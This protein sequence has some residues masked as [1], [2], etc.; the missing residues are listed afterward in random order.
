MIPRQKNGA[1]RR[2]HGESGLAG[3]IA[4]QQ[5]RIRRGNAGRAKA[6]SIND[7][8]DSRIHG[9]SVVFSFP[10]VRGGPTIR[11]A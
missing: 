9:T 8:D 4:R 10:R 2:V 1:K 7:L 5:E 11:R 6:A 3:E